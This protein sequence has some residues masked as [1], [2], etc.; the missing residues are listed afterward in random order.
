MYTHNLTGLNENQI[1]MIILYNQH[2]MECQTI[3][4][5]IITLTLC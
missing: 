4:L 3:T 2:K 5:D 1:Y